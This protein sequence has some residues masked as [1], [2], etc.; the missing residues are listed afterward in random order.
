MKRILIVACLAG[1]MSTIFVRAQKN[2][3]KPGPEYNVLDAWTGNWT[4]LGQARDT[5]SGAA[6]KSEWTFTGR[7][8]LGGFFL[9]VRHRE[10]YKGRVEEFLEI[11]TY[12][13]LKKA[14]VSH[15]YHDNGSWEVSGPAFVDERTCIDNG[16]TYYPDGR[17]KKWRFTWTF[18]ADGKS[19]SV[20]EEDE[21]DGKW[22]TA[23]EG[24]GVKSP[25]K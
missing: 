5:P 13:P 12:D 15:V 11:T 21:Q 2:T 19:V 17:V 1:L 14:C 23:Y 6:Y 22:W 10:K 4:V 25:V 24:Q 18:S 7:R 9:E 16:K 20:K 3:D 8:I